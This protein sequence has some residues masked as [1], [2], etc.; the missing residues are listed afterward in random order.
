MKLNY[1][2]IGERIKILRKQHNIS[3][4]TLAELIGKT[5]TYISRLESGTRGASIETIIEIANALMIST[6]SLLAEYLW[7][8]DELL[9]N[10]FATLLNDCNKHERRVIIGMARSLKMLLREEALL[11]TEDRY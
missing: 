1:L 7:H 6:D 11:F 3:Q 4:Q 10:E 9:N 8:K 2:V 5:P